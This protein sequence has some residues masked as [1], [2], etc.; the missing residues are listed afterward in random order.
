MTNDILTLIFL[1][2]HILSAGIWLSQFVAEFA[3]ERL[4]RARGGKPDAARLLLAEGEVASLLGSVGGTGILISGLVLTFQWHYG[5]LGIGGV[6][7]PTWLVLMQLFY[8]IA[9][10]LVGAVVTRGSSRVTPQIEQAAEAGQPV[11][12]EAQAAMSRV[13]L[14][15]RLV[16]GLVLI[17]FFL[18]VFGVNG[19]Y[20]H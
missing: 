1:A 11:P 14:V 12:V 6:Y 20:L 18:G 5:L 3:V 19:G 4:L 8:I 17:T 10:A 7:T 9:M 2:L 13:V 15:S 16:N